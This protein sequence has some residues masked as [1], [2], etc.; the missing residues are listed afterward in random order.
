VGLSLVLIFVD[1]VLDLLSLLEAGSG[2]T[3]S[4]LSEKTRAEAFALSVALNVVFV[5]KLAVR[6]VSGARKNA[7]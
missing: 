2:K 7:C 5:E 4:C 6:H 3:R 1:R